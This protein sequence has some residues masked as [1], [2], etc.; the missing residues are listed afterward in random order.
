MAGKGERFKNIHQFSIKKP[1][2]K[3]NTRYPYPLVK[4]GKTPIGKGGEVIVK[5]V[6]LDYQH[7]RGLKGLVMKEF[8]DGKGVHVP[9]WDRELRL[10][11]ILAQWNVIKNVAKELRKEGREGFNIPGTVRGVKAEL[12]TGILMT[13]LSEG[14]K[15]DVIDLKKLIFHEE[16]RKVPRAEW[17][18]LRECVLRDVQIGLENN[19]SL[20]REQDEPED[21][22]IDILDPW[23]VVVDKETGVCEL[24]ITDVG[25]YSGSPVDKITVK[26]LAKLNKHLDQVERTIVAEHWDWDEYER[27]NRKGTDHQE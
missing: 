17:D 16:A 10:D 13:D 14:G 20:I 24:V 8:H 22:P 18:K 6:K 11:S 15:K 21:E 1:D 4:V 2:G 3:D 7:V 25:Q 9:R 12:S 5:P 23:T 19:I 27:R 26:D